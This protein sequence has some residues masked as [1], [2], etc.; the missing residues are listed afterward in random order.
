MYGVEVLAAPGTT[1]VSVPE[2]RDHLRLNDQAEDVQ[3][4]ELLAAAVELFEH[5]TARPVLTT[6]Y[7]QSLSYWPCG[8]IVLGKGGVTAVNAV[9]F[10][11]ADG[12][13]SALATDQWRA[14]L[15]TPPASVTLA[16]TPA[17]VTT[18]AGIPVVPVGCVE[19]VAGWATPAAVPRQVRVALKLLAG[20]WY[21]NREAYTERKLDALA[22]GWARVV[23]SHKLGISGPWGM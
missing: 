19:F 2:L 15:A 18:A 23:A 13:P 11:Q 6:T 8:P 21:E 17:I 9:K 14:N 20:H 7:R 1:P 4:A 16:S 12:S 10:Y 3:L 5:D 22:L